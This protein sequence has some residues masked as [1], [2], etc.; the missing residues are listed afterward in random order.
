MAQ[1]VDKVTANVT[2]NCLSCSYAA[3]EA[4]MNQSCI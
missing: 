4:K 3:V 2:Q 1:R